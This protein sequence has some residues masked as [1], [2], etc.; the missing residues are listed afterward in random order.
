MSVFS[1]INLSNPHKK[2]QKIKIQ[3]TVIK[4]ADDNF[5]DQSQNI[6]SFFHA[7]NSFAHK[8]QQDN[9]NRPSNLPSGA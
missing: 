6:L 3:Q 4:Y 1:N 2:H 8:N 7:G 9:L 5:N